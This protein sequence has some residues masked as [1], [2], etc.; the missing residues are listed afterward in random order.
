MEAQDVVTVG[1]VGL[2]LY[3]I[4]RPKAKVEAFP[5]YVPTE[6]VTSTIRFGEPMPDVMEG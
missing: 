4:L 6:L 1:V 2:L 3:L 5:P